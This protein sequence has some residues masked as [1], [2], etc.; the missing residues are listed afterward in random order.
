MVE[1]IEQKEKPMATPV[2]SPLP[3]TPLEFDNLLTGVI[4]NN[5]SAEGLRLGRLPRDVTE[6][7]NAIHRYHLQ[8]ASVMLSP[9]MRHRLE[10]PRGQVRCAVCQTTF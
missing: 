1:Q 8:P 4:K 5:P 6:L 2:L 9:M 7:W 10:A 3:W